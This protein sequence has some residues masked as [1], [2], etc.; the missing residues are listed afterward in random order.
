MGYHLCEL[1]HEAGAELIVT[2]IAEAPVQRAVEQLGAVRVGIEEIYSVDADVFAPC[3]LGGVINDETIGQLR[4]T[5][6]AGSAN[7]QLATSEHGVRLHQM[8]VVYAPDF[9]VNSG[10]MLSA[11]AAFSATTIPGGFPVAWSLCMHHQGSPGR[12]GG[13]GCSAVRGGVTSRYA[14]DR[15]RSPDVIEDGRTALPGLRSEGMTDRRIAGSD[16]D[17]LW[18]LEFRQ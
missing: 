14:T 4:A 16:S 2:D 17:R 7:N 1:L 18:N 8:G 10:G 6:V 15:R 13:Q 12:I 9:L 11:E 3:A 5:V